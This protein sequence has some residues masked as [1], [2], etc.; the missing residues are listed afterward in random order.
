MNEALLILLLFAL[1]IFGMLFIVLATNFGKTRARMRMGKLV[2]FDFQGDQPRST[3]HRNYSIEASTARKH[4]ARIWL[5]LRDHPPS[6]W[7]YDLDGT[8]QYWVFG[9][10]LAC[11]ICLLH[12]PAAIER[13][14]ILSREGRRFFI[15]SLGG[16][17]Y[18]NERTVRAKQTVNNGQEIRIGQ[19]RF[20]FHVDTSGRNNA[21]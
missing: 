6:V 11:D 19:S 17:T 15:R 14:A 9:R 3:S 10:D 5:T 7:R 2:E 13:H 20:V 1:G 18:V 21:A 16:P 12:E 4:R 8:K